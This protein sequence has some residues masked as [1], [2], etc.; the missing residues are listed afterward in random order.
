MLNELK[1]KVVVHNLSNKVTVEQCS[2]TSLDSIKNKGPYD[3]IF[4]ILPV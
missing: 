4:R 1:E 3:L 2:Y